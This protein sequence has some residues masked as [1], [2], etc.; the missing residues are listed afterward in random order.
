MHPLATNLSANDIDYVINKVQSVDI[1][2]PDV[3]P[4]N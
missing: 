3:L 4:Q 1:Y 2:M